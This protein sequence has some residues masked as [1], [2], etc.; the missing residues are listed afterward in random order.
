MRMKCPH[1]GNWAAARSTE[2]VTLTSRKAWLQCSNMEC[3]HT[4][5]AALTVLETLSPS[6]IPNPAVVIPQSPHIQRNV[7]AAQLDRAP[8]S[9]Y[10]P[11]TL[12]LNNLEFDHA[13]IFADLAA[14]ETQFHHL[15][16]TLPA[17]GLIV[18]NGNEAAL[19][20][21]LARA[22]W[23]P[24]ERFNHAGG[25]R[26]S[27]DDA[28]G[29]LILHGPEGEIGR[30]Q[31]ALTGEHNRANACAAL[32]AARHVG[33]DFTHGLAALSRFANVKRRLETRGEAGGVTVY[34]DFAH[35]PTALATTLAGL[36][37]KVGSARI[38]AVFEPRS[39]TMKLGTMKAQ[40]PASLADADLAFCYSGGLD[41]D[42]AA[43]LAPL[44]AKAQVHADLDAL[45]SAIATHAR[46][47]DHVLV[48]SNGG[49][50]GV[51]EKLLAALSA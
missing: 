25:Y 14:I 26:V 23:T 7:L 49:F 39:N 13:D 38:L 45:V 51:H 30:S 44:G 8:L 34:D 35:H 6:A 11:R 9:D 32:L 48:M 27:G 50:G 18:S 22:C 29:E 46:P 17:S 42:A 43:T 31:W 2:D 21:V 16:R 12:V 20:R 33:V 24:V 3:G 10:Q 40:L 28:S 15:V 5:T 1:C 36:R 41:W 4:F 47:G 37:R 19:E